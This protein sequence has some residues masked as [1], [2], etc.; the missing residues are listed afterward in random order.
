MRNLLRN[1]VIPHDWSRDELWEKRDIE[2]HGQHTALRL[3]LAVVDVEKIRQQLK[4][5]KRDAN[6][7]HDGDDRKVTMQQ[8]TKLRHHEGQ[9][10]EDKEQ[11][12]MEHDADC[13]RAPLSCICLC[14]LNAQTDVPPHNNGQNHQPDKHRLTPGIKDQTG[15]QQEVIAEPPRLDEWIVVNQH[16]ERQKEEQEYRR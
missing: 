3:C 13:Q 4:R 6:R 7:Q 1:E 10:L 2:P 12:D 15:Q 11:T 14:S 8:E 5:E 16:H 9:V